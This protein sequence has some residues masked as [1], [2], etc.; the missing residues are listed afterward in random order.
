M[1]GVQACPLT[2]SFS[3]ANAVNVSTSIRA[4][5]PVGEEKFGAKQLELEI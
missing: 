3:Q 2:W 1:F 4:H 5:D